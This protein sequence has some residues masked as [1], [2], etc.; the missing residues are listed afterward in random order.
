LRDDNT[1]EA[2]YS[3]FGVLSDN[4]H[5]GA[6]AHGDNVG[7]EEEM[8]NA[9]GDYHNSVSYMKS[10]RPPLRL[11]WQIVMDGTKRG[12]TVS[13]VFQVSELIAPL[14]KYS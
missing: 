4:N 9:P 1:D 2:H 11:E 13:E 12:R 5:G 3:V 6:Y 10:E 7:D 14:C 8:G